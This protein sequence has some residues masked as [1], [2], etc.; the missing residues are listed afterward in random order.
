MYY[1]VSMDGTILATSERI[2]DN[3]ENLDWE[4]VKASEPIVINCPSGEVALECLEV[5]REAITK[6]QLEKLGFSF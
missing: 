5:F 3:E 4:L 6:D 2:V 1:H